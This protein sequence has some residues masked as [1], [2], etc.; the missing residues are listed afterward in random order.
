MRRVLEALITQL[1][2]YIAVIIMRY[3]KT[4]TRTVLVTSCV[5]LLLV[6][7]S[8]ERTTSFFNLV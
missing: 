6:L 8:K 1:D 2:G 4:V 7:F 5:T 3:T